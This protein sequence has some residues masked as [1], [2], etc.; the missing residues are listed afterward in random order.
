MAGSIEI[1]RLLAADSSA[2]REIR[3]EALRT[4][5]DAFGGAY[6]D[7][8]LNGKAAKRAF[9]Q[10]GTRR[11]DHGELPV[12]VRYILQRRGDGYEAFKAEVFAFWPAGSSN[13]HNMKRRRSFDLSLEIGQRSGVTR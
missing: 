8:C 6:A 2:Y 5:P 9:L 13:E 4:R 11:R 1:R 3:L 7:G 10:L 12:S